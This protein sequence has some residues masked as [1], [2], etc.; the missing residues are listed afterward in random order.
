MDTA[1]RRALFRLSRDSSLPSV[2]RDEKKNSCRQER[3]PRETLTELSFSV[4]LFRSGIY[5]TK[6]LV[7]TYSV[8]VG[9]F[10]CDL[11]SAIPET[12][13]RRRKMRTLRTADDTSYARIIA[14][15]VNE[16]V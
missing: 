3:S 1:G 7:R 8:V 6:I 15:L 12:P 13:Y 14:C 11:T 9:I 4:C 16:R 2:S 5:T 10:F